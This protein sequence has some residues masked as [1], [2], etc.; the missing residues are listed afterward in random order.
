MQSIDS[1]TINFKYFLW[2]V[3]EFLN[4]QSESVAVL[5]NFYKFAAIIFAKLTKKYSEVKLRQSK[6][7]R[8]FFELLMNGRSEQ[9]AP[10]NCEIRS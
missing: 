8:I 2:E 1:K 4:V 6:F 5:L 3:W 7:H 9:L 10:I